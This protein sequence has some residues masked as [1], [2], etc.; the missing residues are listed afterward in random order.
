MTYEL[1][2]KKYKIKITILRKIQLKNIKKINIENR[3][4]YFDH[5]LLII[6]CDVIPIQLIFSQF[7]NGMSWM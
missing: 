3:N 6:M 7:F 1:N 5:Y 4:E 2:R